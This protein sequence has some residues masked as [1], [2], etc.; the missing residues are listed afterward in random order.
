MI[1]DSLLPM[2]ILSGVCESAVNSLG[3]PKTENK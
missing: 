1:N 2:P 3:L